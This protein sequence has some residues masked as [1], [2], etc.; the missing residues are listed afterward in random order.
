MKQRAFIKPTKANLVVGIIVTA[1]FA[2]FGIVFFA[3]LASEGSAIGMGFM[4]FWLLIVF[5]IGGSYVYSLLKYNKNDDMITAG[6]IDLDEVDGKTS[7]SFDEK[8]RKLEQLKKEGL[9]SEKEF[10]TKRN[11]IMN[12]KW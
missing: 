6:V 7:I 12:Q 5:V 9:I 4:V 1:F 8:L 3:V 2:I 10:N 11:E